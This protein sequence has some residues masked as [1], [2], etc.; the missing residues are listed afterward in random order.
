MKSDGGLRS[1]FRKH[2]PKV[3]F[4][5]I[6]SRLT[7]AGIPDLHGIADGG[8]AFWIENKATKG[9]AVRV[10]PLQSAWLRRYAGK[11]GYC[12]LA[13]RRRS[14]RGEDELW[15]VAGSAA[16]RLATGGLQGLGRGLL[17]RWAGGP[18]GWP[19]LTVLALVTRQKA[20]SRPR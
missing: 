11:G 3:F 10:R 15:L 9:Y 7:Q 13:V 18:A 5:T 4:T 8:P 2:L 1:L 6:E 14:S 17:G 20:P 19:W 12:A 16:H